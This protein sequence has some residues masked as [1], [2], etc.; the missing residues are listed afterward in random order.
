MNY[1]TYFTPDKN[2]LVMTVRYGGGLEDNL[3][4]ERKDCSFCFA[5]LPFKVEEDQACVEVKTAVQ[6]KSF[7][8]QE[9]RM[10]PC[11]R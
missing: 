8:I 9:I 7:L 1:L 5:M 6:R 11:K 10:R 2:T 4:T 3:A